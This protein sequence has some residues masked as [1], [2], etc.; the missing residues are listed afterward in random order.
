MDWACEETGHGAKIEEF[1]TDCEQ[2]GKDYKQGRGDTDWASFP[3]TSWGRE[4]PSWPRATGQFSTTNLLCLCK[5][6]YTKYFLTTMFYFLQIICYYKG[7][8]T[9]DY[10]L[11][12][13]RMLLAYSIMK[14]DCSGWNAGTWVLQLTCIY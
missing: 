4:D 14:M 12:L 6:N 11:W 1:S 13:I 3:K 8:L 5:G 10:Y 7:V 9:I 2:S